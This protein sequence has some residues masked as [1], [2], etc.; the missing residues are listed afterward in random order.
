MDDFLGWCLDLFVDYI[1]L[2]SSMEI[3]SGVS[4]FAFLIAVFVLAAVINAF[5]LRSH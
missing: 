1:A 4:L 2:L 5:L 3:A